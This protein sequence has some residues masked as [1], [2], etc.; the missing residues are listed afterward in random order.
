[1]AHCEFILVL[2]PHQHTPSEPTTDLIDTLEIDDR[3]PLDAQE[4]RR[5]EPGLQV[6]KGQLEKEAPLRG[7]DV[8]V[9]IL[10]D[11]M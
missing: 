8:R 1:V 10:G 7:L 2:Q 3:G 9:A 5:F 11:E 6:S 4:L